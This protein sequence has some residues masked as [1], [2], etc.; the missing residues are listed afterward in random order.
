MWVSPNHP[1]RERL[2]FRQSAAP[3]D[4]TGRPLATLQRG[5]GEELRVSLDEFEG[6]PFVSLR[7]WAPGPTGELWPVR[8][9]GVSVRVRE[10]LDVADALREAAD[11]AG[12][13]RPTGRP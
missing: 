1:E 12:G 10:L 6:H 13:E 8:G 2:L 11:L 7:V 5:R 9:K 3:P 4:P